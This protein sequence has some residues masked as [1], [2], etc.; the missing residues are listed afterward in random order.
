M[1]GQRVA[2]GRGGRS[3]LFTALGL[4]GMVVLYLCVAV[5]I[6]YLAK[7]S[8]NFKDGGDTLFYVHRGELLYRSIT[9]EGN[10]YPIL[11]LSWY[12]GVQTWRYW[13]PLSAYILAFCQAL[14]GGDSDLGF[15]LF[16]ALLY[17]ACAL[18]WLVLGCTHGRPWMGAV[19][20]LIWFLVPNNVFMFFGEGVLARSISL[21]AMPIFFVAL[22]DYLYERRWSALPAMI[23]SFLFIILCHVGWAGMI[24]ISA[25]FYL[26]FY[27]L[28]LR[29]GDR[30]GVF[31]VLACMI[32]AFLISG[33]LL[34]PNLVGGITGIDSSSVMASYFQPLWDSLSPFLGAGEGVWN[35]FL[36]LEIPYFG[37]AALLLGALG[38]LCAGRGSSPGFWTALFILLLTTPTA[39]Q[40]LVHMPG[41]QYLWMTR[42]MSIALCILL[43]SFFFWTTLKRKLQTAF[44][45]LFSAEL[46][47]AVAMISHAQQ[48]LAPNDVFDSVSRGML[49]DQGQAVT[50][51][52][53]TVMDPYGVYY[54]GI[55]TGASHG[56]SPKPTSYGQGIQAA[57]DYSNLIQLNQADEDE[58]YLYLFDRALELGNDTVILPMD[59]TLRGRERDLQALQSAAE[60]VGYRLVEKNLEYHLYHIDAP[61]TFGVVSKY[62]AIAI[63]SGSGSIA[64]GFPAVRETTDPCLDNYTYEELRQYDVIYLAGFT[65]RDQ[66]AA[67]DLVLRLSESG[68][69]VVILADGIPSDE[70]TGSKSFLGVSCNTVNFQNGYPALDTV[71]GVLY[72]DLFARGYSKD[73]KTVYLNGL[74]DVWGTI[75]DVPE[76]RMDFYGTGQNENL[77]YIG[78]ALTYHYALTQDPAV[79]MLLSHALTI[80]P[81]ELPRRELV[82]ISMDYRDNAIIIDSPRDG[83]NTTLAYQDIFDAD[84]PLESQNNLLVVEEGRTVIRL[85]Y[86]YLVQG[87]CL[88]AVGLAATAAYLI[89]MKKRLKPKAGN[90]DG[91]TEQESEK[92]RAPI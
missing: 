90:S 25:L 51:Q 44:L 76:G 70:H 45:L 9:Q 17:L 21:P 3:R 12:N 83:V 40:I 31:P 72:C 28:I 11:D 73:W 5:V 57:S 13:S 75:T 24:A 46:L 1:E 27:F 56:E 32:L 16:T 59:S 36:F 33:L 48:P 35:R 26:V 62:R 7:L 86:P 2:P 65:Y 81:S 68:V 15:L 85:R 92:E 58:Q 61:A 49:I 39:Y 82:P 55:Y 19:L 79:G 47:C 54:L 60:Q 80:D 78:L 77:V 10:W 69:R 18:V 88:S 67:E 14:A 23:L 41:A 91:P 6:A 50:T 30:A 34:I 38:I 66:T 63:G 52:R 74:S 53:M 71:D 20:G 43:V 29:K 89:L 42:F 64:L 22:H 8:G 84:R 37:M 87:L 4:A